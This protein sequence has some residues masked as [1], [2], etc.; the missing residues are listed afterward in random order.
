MQ[1]P[2][3]KI[4][5]RTQLLFEAIN[6]GAVFT[7]AREAANSNNLVCRYGGIAEGPGERIKWGNVPIAIRRAARE[8]FASQWHRALAA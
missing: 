5:R 4:T 3:F 8:H 7:I 6:G 2:P 1:E